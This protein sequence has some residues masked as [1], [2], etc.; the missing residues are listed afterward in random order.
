MIAIMVALSFGGAVGWI[1]R[2]RRANRELLAALTRR[3][4][5]PASARDPFTERLLGESE[6][7]VAEFLAKELPGESVLQAGLLDVL[8][9][10]LRKEWER[11]PP[12]KPMLPGMTATVRPLIRAKVRHVAEA[13]RKID[14]VPDDPDPPSSVFH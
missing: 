14:D 11:E 4:P 2:G 1:L 7:I 10:G 6:L 3:A 13:A 8:M 9:S 12:W 5:G